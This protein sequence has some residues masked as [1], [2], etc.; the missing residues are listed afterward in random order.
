MRSAKVI[1][2]SV[3]NELMKASVTK[4]ATLARPSSKVSRSET[5]NR[6]AMFTSFDLKVVQLFSAK[7][8]QVEKS[9]TTI[10]VHVMS[11][12]SIILQ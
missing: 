6:P 1:D 11:I 9:L 2:E 7:S 4:L 5:S 3:V 8:S 12:L 10:V